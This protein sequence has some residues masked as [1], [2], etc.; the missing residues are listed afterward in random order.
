MK[1]K[2]LRVW[3]V[4]YAAALLAALLCTAVRQHGRAACV[5]QALPLAAAQLSSIRTD[6]PAQWANF[7]PGSLVA[8]DGDPFLVW[9]VDGPVH[10][11]QMQVR[12]S[13]P[14]RDP[15]VYYTTAPGQDWSGSR[16]LPLVE[17]DPAAGVYRF[18]LPKAVQVSAL[19]LDP[20]S[21][22]GAFFALEEITLNPP[23]Q[24]LPLTA[25]EVLALVLAPL[26][27]VLAGQELAALRRR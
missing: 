4:V 15:Q 25:G 5:P 6:H 12:S 7:G 23:P 2:M 24:G 22:A 13:Q 20:T 8:T 10:S 1:Q 21:S 17:S 14:I 18:A 11:L 27:A 19:R 26:L 3:A 16:T 9:Q